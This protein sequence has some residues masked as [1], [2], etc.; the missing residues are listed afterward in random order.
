MDL[1]ILELTNRFRVD[2]ALPP[3]KW[4]KDLAGIAKR[5]ATAVAEGTAPFSHDGAQGRFA[6]CKTKCIN[7]AENLARSD[8]FAREVLPIEAVKGW[9]QSAGHRRNLLGPFDVCGI[10]WAASDSGTIF[11]TQLLALLDERSSR[12]G[13]LREMAFDMAVASSTPLAL[14]AIGMAFAGPAIALGGGIFGGA[15]DYK[16]GL[17]ATNLPLVARDKLKGLMNRHCCSRCG[18][19]TATVFSVV[20]D[21]AVASAGGSGR[22]S[23]SAGR[24]RTDQPLFANSHDGRLLCS[25]CQP[26]PSDDDWCFIE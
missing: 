21:A 17:K 7:V 3:L 1:E 6:C 2:H 11:V 18:R 4:S 5:H 9:C 24:E 23:S 25:S 13:Q 16:Y 12:R 14:S 10:G 19:T 26:V 22:A 20:A 8:G 15:V